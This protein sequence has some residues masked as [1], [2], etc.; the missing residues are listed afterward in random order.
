MKWHWGCKDHYGV[1]ILT[2]QMS[3]E[4]LSYT[5]D[6]TAHSIIYDVVEALIRLY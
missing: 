3:F 4:K 2:M 5:C 6:I 1:K